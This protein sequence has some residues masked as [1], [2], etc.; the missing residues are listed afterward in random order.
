MLFLPAGRGFAGRGR[1]RHRLCG[2]R[3]SFGITWGTEGKGFPAMR[4]GFSLFGDGKWCAEQWLRS[5]AE[6]R[7]TRDL[8]FLGFL[9][10]VW[11]S[12][13]G[14]ASLATRQF[15]SGVTTR[16]WCKSSR[17]AQVMRLVRKFIL[18]WLKHNIMVSAEHVPGVTNEMLSLV[19]SFTCF[20]P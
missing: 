10:I 1:R 7:I 20:G 5:W 15:V 16:W 9:P 3:R 19:S 4:P 17:S 8:T 6:Q 14:R 12:S 13:Y 11:Q 2:S 18:H